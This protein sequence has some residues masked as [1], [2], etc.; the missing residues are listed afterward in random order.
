MGAARVGG[1]THLPPESVD[2]TTPLIDAADLFRVGHVGAEVGDA[3][4][5]CFDAPVNAG[6]SRI[7]HGG[8][9]QRQRSE[10]E[11]NGSEADTRAVPAEACQRG[12]STATSRVWPTMRLMIR[13]S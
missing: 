9:C 5:A 12:R 4:V 6:H 10:M 13:N 11:G 2:Q 3:G 8:G 7:T 1:T